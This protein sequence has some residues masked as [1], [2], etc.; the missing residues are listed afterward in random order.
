MRSYLGSITDE[1]SI[2]TI[3]QSISKQ[4]IGLE[5]MSRTSWWPYVKLHWA[6]SKEN[7]DLFHQTP[8]ARALY[9]VMDWTSAGDG[10]SSHV[11][12]KVPKSYV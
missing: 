8:Q 12:A 5:G 2:C 4:L 3:I 7:V 6:N 1:N 10:T 9:A 11:R